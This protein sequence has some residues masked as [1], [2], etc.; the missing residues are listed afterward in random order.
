MDAPP[1]RASDERPA[2]RRTPVPL[3]DHL[4][5]LK[6]FV[7]PT[8]SGIV[9][10][11]HGGEFPTHRQAAQIVPPHPTHFVV[12]VHGMSDKVMAGGRDLNAKDTADV[13]RA[14]GWDGKQPVLLVGCQTGSKPDGF[15]AQLSRELGGEVTAPTKDAWTDDRGNL[16]ASSSH[17]GARDMRPG[18]PPNGEWAT[19]KPDGTNTA[20]KQSSPPGHV[21]DWR[22]VGGEGPDRAYR[23]GEAPGS[24]NG[25]TTSNPSWADRLDP[26]DSPQSQRK[27]AESDATTTAEVRKPT[28]V[29][30]EGT[31][32]FFENRP[33]FRAAPHDVHHMRQ[34]YPPDMWERDAEHIDAIVARN[35]HLAVIPRDQLIAL[36][37]HTAQHT[38]DTV[39][40]AL[41]ANDIPTLRRHEGYVKVINSALNHLPPYRGVVHRVI[42]TS[43]APLRASQF[44]MHATITE[45]AFLSTSRG[46]PSDFPGKVVMEIHSLTGRDISAVSHRPSEREVLFPSGTRF[47]VV[48]TGYNKETGTFHVQLR[49]EPPLRPWRP[50]AGYQ[51]Q[52]RPQVLP[53][54]GQQMPRHNQSV[55]NGPQ[56][57]GPL[58]P[59][60]QRPPMPPPQQHRQQY[61]PQQQPVRPPAPQHVQQQQPVRPQPYPQ[62]QYQQQHRQQPA[63]VQQR[64]QPSVPDRSQTTTALPR[65]LVE[66]PPPPMRQETYTEPVT[67][68]LRKPEYDHTSSR[69]QDAP[70][71]AADDFLARI[72]NSPFADHPVADA[73]PPDFKRVKL[74]YFEDQERLPHV[75]ENLRGTQA[76]IAI[77]GPSEKDQRLGARA[78]K[79]M[80]GY[81]VVDTHGQ[82]DALL[83][84]GKQLNGN[85]VVNILNALPHSVWD[86]KT[87]IIF[88]GCNS[89]KNPNGI[90]A[91]VA[92]H[93]G[94][95]TIAPRTD[96]WVDDKGNIYAAETALEPGKSKW[97]PNGEWARFGPDGTGRPTS[98]SPY[99]PGHTPD[100]GLHDTPA[101]R[102]HDAFQRG[103]DPTPPPARLTADD[104]RAYLERPDVS[105]ALDRAAETNSMV[106]EKNK[107]GEIVAQ[108][109][110]ADVVRERLVDH[111]ELVEAMTRADY[112]E[113]ALLNQ[114]KTIASLLLQPKAIDT[115][116]GA[117]NDVD[118]GAQAVIDTAARQ[119][120]QYTPLTSEQLAI[121]AAVERQLS[122]VKPGVHNVQIPMKP[123]ETVES[124][125][126]ARFEDARQARPKLIELVTDLARQLDGKAGYRPFDKNRADVDNY[127]KPDGRYKGDP[128][129]AKDL[130]AGK[131]EFKRLSD[132][133]RAVEMISRREDLRIVEFNDRFRTPQPSGYR[134]LQMYI[135]LPPNDHVTELRL[136]L[137]AMD[138]VAVYEHALY[139]VN[140]QYKKDIVTTQEEALVK[141]INMR[142]RVLFW[143]ALHQEGVLE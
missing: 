96:T 112:L 101:E 137:T 77:F 106:D 139:E 40:R 55:Y 92:R 11:R 27:P 74:D 59:N 134:D 86:R 81:F 121:S 78:I 127:A 66:Q 13:I 140:R 85:D 142:Q 107:A 16:F 126:D 46:G 62:Q 20:H 111:P 90:P 39:N 26:P 104:V 132:V 21:P 60:Q 32:L 37:G 72:A 35:P 56:Q 38:F 71:P 84:N 33:D 44:P 34:S 80:P 83:S 70:A 73:P 51:Q 29:A 133:Y 9:I 122:R 7:T 69:P 3:P 50:V 110:I 41:R 4:K 1:A 22:A 141:A 117:V 89:G 63:P 95:E 129:L 28:I 45:R 125:L 128:R 124:Y 138:E 113:Q 98:D 97:P 75:V 2:P 47:T 48:G 6:N 58:P 8:Q 67:Q 17:Q 42:N 143:E 88:T 61:P 43:D 49:E 94:V 65:P 25:P 108:H 14:S 99:P 52:P 5:D 24:S 15:A 12:D 36:R 136:H 54:Q 105:A 130:T 102:P 91:H 114:P 57:G 76:G 118:A 109:R 18:W 123:G 116:V 100:W 93:F 68:P 120:A 131:I 119:P 115:V 87:P 31:P 79:P 30:P 23:R 82:A 135:T 103:E 64:P 53:V 19:F 10:A